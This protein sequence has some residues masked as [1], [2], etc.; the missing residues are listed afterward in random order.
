MPIFSTFA[1]YLGASLLA[2]SLFPQTW[3]LHSLHVVLTTYAQSGYV[4]Q[5]LDAL[6]QPHNKSPC[7]SSDSLHSDEQNTRRIGIRAKILLGR[8]ISLLDTHC[9]ILF[10][11]SVSWAVSNRIHCLWEDVVW[12]SSLIWRLERYLQDGY[13]LRL[14]SSSVATERMENI[15]QCP[16]A[17]ATTRSKTLLRYPRTRFRSDEQTILWS[18][19]LLFRRSSRIYKPWIN[20]KPFIKALHILSTFFAFS[21]EHR[22]KW[23]SFWNVLK[24]G[25]YRGIGSQAQTGQNFSVRVAFLQQ[26]SIEAISELPSNT[27]NHVF[28]GK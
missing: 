20:V 18:L 3:S 6:L 27:A 7:M 4:A 16:N 26:I 17:F 9:L 13:L 23:H 2:W 22:R 15:W 28:Q 24:C 14:G 5:R 21:A 10:R 19:A 25:I 1:K 8:L 12:C 11:T